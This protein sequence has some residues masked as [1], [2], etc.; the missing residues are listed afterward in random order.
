MTL[1]RLGTGPV[2]LVP[3]LARHNPTRPS[4]EISTVPA[5]ELLRPSRIYQKITE[6]YAHRTAEILRKEEIDSEC[7][8]GG[9]LMT[10]TGLGYQI[11]HREGLSLGRFF[12]ALLSQG[13]EGSLGVS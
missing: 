4:E 1:I 8:L 11:L 5:L 6:Q 12:E 10:E 7:L 13:E 9:I 2:R 3:L